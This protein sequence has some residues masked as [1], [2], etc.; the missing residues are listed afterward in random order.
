MNNAFFCFIKRSTLFLIICVAS[1]DSAFAS[2]SITLSNLTDNQANYN[3]QMFYYKQAV[4]NDDWKNLGA[5]QFKFFNEPGF[6]NNFQ[7]RDGRQQLN[8]WTWLNLNLVK[9][10][11]EQQERHS[12]SLTPNNNKFIVD[13]QTN[14]LFIHTGLPAKTENSKETPEPKLL[15]FIS[16]GFV[17]LGS[18]LRQLRTHRAEKVRI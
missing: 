8:N 4:N 18:M 11:P 6:S 17:G 14:Q 2:F 7:C 12:E 13:K 10:S 9:P 3:Q 16:L 1:L 15:S 5:G